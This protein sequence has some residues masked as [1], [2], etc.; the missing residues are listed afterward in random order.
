MRL[1]CKLYTW[2]RLLMKGVDNNND[3]K[4]EKEKGKCM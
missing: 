3:Q 1:Y 2:M 4:E